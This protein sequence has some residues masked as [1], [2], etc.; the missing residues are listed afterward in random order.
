MIYS[1][2]V[3][4]LTTPKEGGTT[5]LWDVATM[6]PLIP[7]SQKDLNPQI[8]YC[9]NFIFCKILSTY[10]WPEI[11]QPIWGFIFKNECELMTVILTIIKTYLNKPCLSF[12]WGCTV[13]LLWLLLLGSRFSLGYRIV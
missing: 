11:F 7:S 8:Q 1:L 2:I 6:H 5:F 4:R 13:F 9:E 10:K 12:H 3:T